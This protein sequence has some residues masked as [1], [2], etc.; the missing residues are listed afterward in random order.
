M[1][2]GNIA[3]RPGTN[4]QNKQDQS[5]TH[6]SRIRISV[7]LAGLLVHGL[8]VYTSRYPCALAQ[9]TKTPSGTVTQQSRNQVSGQPGGTT[10]NQPPKKTAT[11][12]AQNVRPQATTA[13]R[14]QGQTSTTEFELSA[15]TSE[16]SDHFTGR[17]NILRADHLQRAW[18]RT[19][20]TLAKSRTYTKTKVNETEL[21]T[22]TADIGFRNGGSQ[23]YQFVRLAA[24]YRTRNPNLPGYPDRAG[25]SMLAVGIGRT[26]LSVL[27]C[28]VSLAGVNK[29]NKD[30]ST[31]RLVIPVYSLGLKAPVTTSVT[32]DGD[33]RLMEPFTSDSL[34]DLRLN[35][36]YRLT[37]ALSLRLSYLANNML[38][39]LLIPISHRPKTDW[40]KSFRISLVFS[41]SAK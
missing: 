27:E 1:K 28:E 9:E 34:V 20:Y 36:T 8:F 3:L 30:G 23:S 15:F 29:I 12:A 24:N 5:H 14:R 4:S 33:L 39:N 11:P 13:Q 16:I 10:T 31:D 32:V 21:G 35:L 25:Y 38:N 6:K 41:R 18:M 37:P 19:G 26:V 2:G 17:I 22:I 40:D 7:V